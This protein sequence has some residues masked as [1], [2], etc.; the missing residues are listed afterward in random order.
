LD[1]ATNVNQRILQSIL[2]GHNNVSS[3]R[4]DTN[5][6][7]KNLPKVLASLTKQ[8]LIKMQTKGWKKGKSIPCSI[9]N[10]GISW[11][12]NTSLNETLRLL[13][14]ISDQLRNPQNREIF[15]NAQAEKYYQNCRIIRDYFIERLLKNNNS[16]LEYPKDVDSVD[17]N[18]PFRE[19]LKKVLLLHMYLISDPDKGIEEL[20]DSLE[21]DFVFFGPHM[22]FAF[23]LHPGAFPE[24]DYQLQ[25]VEN[26]LLSESQKLKSPGDM[27]RKRKDTH[28]LDLETVEEKAFEEYV[29]AK[30]STS[31][32]KIL[33]NIE[34][35]VGWSV[36]KYLGDLTTG[37]ENELAKYIDEKD[38]PYLWKFI[39][40]FENKKI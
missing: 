37:K 28:L 10:D 5:I 22:T 16:E 14:N 34:K 33:I 15:K 8:G 7:P 3:I 23:S 29:N 18:E 40:L 6:H 13:S 27:E 2:S 32:Q 12:T 30:R 38:R 25:K 4:R 1:E 24:L 21:K 11:L 26:Y 39:R 9:T 19:L 35:Q 17:F 31:R 36:G 20:E